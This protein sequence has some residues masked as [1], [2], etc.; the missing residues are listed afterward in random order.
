MLEKANRPGDKMTG[1]ASWTPVLYLE[2]AWVEFQ[3]A[4]CDC[5][6]HPWNN[7]FAALQSL[8]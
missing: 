8:I 5:I 1:R 7:L 6:I 3:L 2:L 4:T